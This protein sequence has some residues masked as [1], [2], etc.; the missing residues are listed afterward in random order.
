MSQLE[1]LQA[2]ANITGS[3]NT[4]IGNVADASAGD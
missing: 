4:F 2:L 3:N 1:L